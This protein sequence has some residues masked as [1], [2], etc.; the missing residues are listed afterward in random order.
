MCSKRD[1]IV[2][3]L[4][5]QTFHTLSHILL[6]V[7]HSLPLHFFSIT[8][9]SHSNLILILVNALITAALAWWLYRLEK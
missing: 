9:T 2:F 5:A 3:F 7:S 6:G 1:L 4:G 8:V